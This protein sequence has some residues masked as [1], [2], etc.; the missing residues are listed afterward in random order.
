LVQ[1]AIAKTDA[2]MLETLDRLVLGKDK[3]QAAEWKAPV[4]ILE[5]SKTNGTL[6]VRPPEPL[7]DFQIPMSPHDH[8]PGATLREAQLREF[9]RRSGGVVH[10]GDALPTRVARQ[11]SSLDRV[12]VAHSR[13]SAN[14]TFEQIA[15][16]LRLGEKRFAQR[17]AL[18]LDGLPEPQPGLRGGWQL[19]R[20]KL[21]VFSGEAWRSLRE[22]L[23]FEKLGTATTV[24]K[25]DE[26]ALL[27]ELG[28]GSENVLILIAHNAEGRIYFPDGSSMDMRKI[29]QLERKVA[30]DRAVVLIT[31]EAGGTGGDVPSLAETLLR[32]R[33]AAAVF[34]SPKVI[35]AGELPALLQD[36][37]AKPLGDALRLYHIEQYVS[38]E[39]LRYG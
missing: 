28:Q 1:D 3:A 19:F 13:F 23:A 36:L 24:R 17:P 34:A 20:M 9:I 11:L 4:R 6:K 18:V 27:S 8:E 12:A 26:A 25:M 15:G 39:S 10:E 2:G 35:D 14:R 32:N 5:Y 7:P 21:D 37:A 22:R 16:A 33:L 30:P 38:L 29:E 31:C